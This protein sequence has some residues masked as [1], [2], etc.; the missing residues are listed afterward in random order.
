[1][2]WTKE[3]TFKLISMGIGLILALVFAEIGMRIVPNGFTPRSDPEYDMHDKVAYVLKQ[4]HEA[5]VV[6]QC[7]ENEDFAVNSLGFRGPEWESNAKPKIAILGDSYMEAQRTRQAETTAGV[8]QRLTGVQVLNAGVA[9]YNNFHQHAVYQEF[10]G[11]YKPE[12]VALFLFYGNDIQYNHCALAGIVNNFL[13]CGEV[14]ND[15]V[16]Y[17]T[18][19]ESK[20]LDRGAFV[21]PAFWEKY[22]VGQVWKFIWGRVKRKLGGAKQQQLRDFQ[23]LEYQIFNKAATEPWEEAWTITE[24]ILT[25][26][27]ARVAENGGKLIIVPIPTQLMLTEQWEED[28]RTVLPQTDLST[29]QQSLPGQKLQALCTRN[30]IDL[31]DLTVPFKSYL[32]NNQMGWPYFSWRCDAH[33]NPLGHYLAANLLAEHIMG[34][35]LVQIDSTLL[36]RIQNNFLRSPQEIL[37]SD[38]YTLLY[39]DGVLK[40][41]TQISETV[42]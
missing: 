21:K 17:T 41:P 36:P 27:K 5:K 1:M 25:D 19:T 42:F 35:R 3:T 26:L 10:L 18:I 11:D 31:L 13:P 29:F 8:L 40:G 7:V 39:E 28:L 20:M 6:R 38:S 2:K 23:K 34:E 24:Q 30:G 37:G 9:G 15:E 22:Y 33:W 32:K 14:N 12:V 4:D 16:A